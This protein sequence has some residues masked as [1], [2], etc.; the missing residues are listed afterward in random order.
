[1]MIIGIFNFIN[2]FTVLFA[3]KRF[4]NF[5]D[6]FAKFLEWGAKAQLYFA[7]ATDERPPLIPF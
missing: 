3:G 1:M 4:Q 2:F 6:Y 7:G 5:Y